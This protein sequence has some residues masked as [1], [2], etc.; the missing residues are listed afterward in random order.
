MQLWHNPK[1]A[2]LEL[3]L[4]LSTKI[5]ISTTSDNNDIQWRMFQLTSVPVLSDLV[6]TF[7][8]TKWQLLVCVTIAYSERRN[9]LYSLTPR[10]RVHFA[11]L[12]VS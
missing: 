3:I 7:F 4:R 2:R 11:K 6:V 8:N 5:S 1:T 10:R 12:V 9:I